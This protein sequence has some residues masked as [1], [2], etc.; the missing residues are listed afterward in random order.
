M[1]PYD[2]SFNCQIRLRIDL[3]MSVSAGGECVVTKC[4]S[5][6]GFKIVKIIFCPFYYEECDDILCVAVAQ[7]DDEDL[8]DSI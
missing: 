5:C 6:N 2:I 1:W 7:G 3:F 4:S 8:R